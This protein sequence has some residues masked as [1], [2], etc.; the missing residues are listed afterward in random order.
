MA[1]QSRVI[2]QQTTINANVWIASAQW[3][4]AKTVSSFVVFTRRLC[5]Y[6]S[7]SLRAKR[8]NPELSATDYDINAHAWIA[9][10]LWS[11]AK[12][13]TTNDAWII[14]NYAS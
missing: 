11:F 2:R 8:S 7:S 4:L 14:R 3:S 1:K 10:A 5:E 12:T 6:L 9:S 13:V